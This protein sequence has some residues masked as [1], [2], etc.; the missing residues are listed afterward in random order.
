MFYFVIEKQKI[1]FLQHVQKFILQRWI[2]L[3]KNQ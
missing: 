3:F 2:C 1:H